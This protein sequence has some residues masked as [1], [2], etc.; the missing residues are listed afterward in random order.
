MGIFSLVIAFSWANKLHFYFYGIVVADRVSLAATLVVS[1]LLLKKIAFKLE[2]WPL[3]IFVCLISLPSLLYWIL[4]EM[5][6]VSQYSW[7]LIHLFLVITAVGIRSLMLSRLLYLSPVA[8]GM[9]FFFPFNFQKEQL[10]FYDRLES[11]IE[12]RHGEAQIV[13]WKGDLWMYYN[14]QLQFSTVDKHMFQ[15]A[16]VQPIMQFADENSKVLLIGGDN[17]M[18]ESEL[19]KFSI[20]LTILPIDPEFHSFSRTSTSIPFNDVADKRSIEK[21]DV[22]SYLSEQI[23]QFDIVIIDTPDPLSLD[24][25]QYYSKEFYGLVSN[26][27]KKDGFMVTQS[28]ALFKNGISVQRIWNSV[29]ESGF[30]I[31]PAQCQIPT[32]GHW[33]WVIGSKDKTPDQMK[34]TLSK[35]KDQSTVW[36]NQEAADMMFSFG[37][38]YFGNETTAVNTLNPSIQ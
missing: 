31:L 15:E 13:K 29:E 30:Y 27:L 22:L 34:E 12:T 28:G 8:L 6:V 37:K 25:K 36:W 23:N 16:Y 14:N 10:R 18:V 17:G 9:V 11:S 33:S 35:V 26:S 4:N 19:S 20:S 2:R 3:M 7:L 24:Y 38:N 5:V 1:L 32:I 21:K